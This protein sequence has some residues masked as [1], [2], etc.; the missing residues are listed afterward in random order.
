[1]KN[2][3]RKSFLSGLTIFL[4]VFLVSALYAANR[5]DLS[6]RSTLGV[7]IKAAD[8]N[9]TLGLSGNEG[10]DLL[11]Q[12]TDRNGITHAR[13]SQL[14]NGIPVWGEQIIISKDKAGNIL[15]FRGILVEGISQDV[16]A[17]KQLASYDTAAALKRMKQDLEAKSPDTTWIFKNESSKV[18]IYV[19]ANSVAHVAY[20][21]SFFADSQDGGSP[22][23]PTYIFDVDTGKML[24]TY[25]G[26]T[27]ANGGGPGGNEKIGQ[28]EYGVDY[29]YFEVAQSGTT[30]TMNNTNVKTVN[31]NHGTSGTTAYSFTC[32]T[33][34]YQYIN[35]AYSPLND[36]HFFGKIVF[37][38]YNNWYGVPPLTF[39]LTMRVHY[40]NNYENAFWDGSTMTF[41]DGYTKFYPLVS[42]DVVAHEVSHG[43][44]EQNSDLTYSGQSGGINE[45]FS[46]IAGEAAENYMRGSNDF[47]IGYDIMKGSGALR[48]MEDPPLD[49]NS[50]GSALDY[51]SGMNVHYSS[52][53]Y[54]K[55]FYTLAHTS[56]W[57]THK[58]FDVFV[59]ANQDYWTPST[60][61]TQGAEGVRDAGIDLGYSAVDIVNAFAAV[62][63]NISSGVG[64]TANFS[65][66]VSDQTVTFTD[67]S[68]NS[69]GNNVAWLWNFG[70]GSTSTAQNPTHTYSSYADYSVSLRVTDDDG[71]WN[72]T[73]KT[74]AVDAPKSFCGVDPE[75]A[76]KDSTAAL[77]SV[78]RI[79]W[80]LGF[81][82]LTL[83][84]VGVTRRRKKN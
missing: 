61:F 60:N 16:K 49:G 25:E 6:K 45:A 33:N 84:I 12:R 31:L 55:A 36:A 32:P 74:V 9:S 83:I 38:L 76:E 41:G 72:Q 47:L 53:V 48:Y 13:Y 5:V 69:T 40:S 34:T 77:T 21:V 52:G 64:P 78:G 54:N 11:R 39:Q 80:P 82:M 46:D 4:S 51:Y 56:G 71:L 75:Y 10:L 7:G 73:S 67:T 35:G 30:C 22:T 59:K 1:M 43:F 58:A 68:T 70:D 81:A 19:D 42:L 20:A 2:F 50:I 79:F 66:S 62:D 37:D 8:A 3:L 26:L 18:V 29:P 65:Y 15:R 17:A 44:T 14:Y 57:T 63:V 24:F 28:Y 27:Y 23:R